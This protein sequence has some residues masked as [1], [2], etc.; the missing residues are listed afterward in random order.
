MFVVRE[1]FIPR[2]PNNR[3]L[4]GGIP[5]FISND[6]D[7]FLCRQVLP[8]RLSGITDDTGTS[9]LIDVNENEIAFRALT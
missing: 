9:G 6:I 3:K 8:K 7:N 5:L 4:V 1:H 2:V